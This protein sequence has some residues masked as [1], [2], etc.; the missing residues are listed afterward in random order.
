M[1]YTDKESGKI[2]TL[3]E[4]MKKVELMTYEE[5]LA[6]LCEVHKQLN[7][8]PLKKPEASC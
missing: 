8:E 5:K 7:I 2:L 1:T 6:I 4:A 3:E